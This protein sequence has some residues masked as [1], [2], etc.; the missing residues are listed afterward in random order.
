MFPGIAGV[1]QPAALAPVSGDPELN[2]TIAE[3]SLTD[4]LFKQRMKE[5]LQTIKK[6]KASPDGI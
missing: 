5:Y 1:M 3:L 4:P 2:N 6:G